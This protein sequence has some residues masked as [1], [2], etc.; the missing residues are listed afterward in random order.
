MI[1]S[2]KI[3]VVKTCIRSDNGQMWLARFA[4]SKQALKKDRK[5]RNQRIRRSLLIYERRFIVQVFEFEDACE[6]EQIDV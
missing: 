3:E 2:K 4:Q 5:R 1:Y 6:E